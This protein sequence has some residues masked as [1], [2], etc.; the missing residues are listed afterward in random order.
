MENISN[1]SNIVTPIA[2]KY[3]ADRVALFGSR[4]RNTANETSDYDFIISKGKIQSLF[5]L[6][7]FIDEL[8]KA[9]GGAVDVITD[10]SSDAGFL[11]RIKKDEVVVYEAQR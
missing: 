3:G 2:Q 5:Q 11:D 8:E 9:F 6:A 7:A 10:T 4:A 1:I